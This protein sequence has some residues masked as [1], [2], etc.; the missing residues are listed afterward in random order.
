MHFRKAAA[1]LDSLKF[2]DFDCINDFLIRVRFEVV[3]TLFWLDHDVTTTKFARK[4]INEVLGLIPLDSALKLMQ[5]EPVQGL[6]GWFLAKI[7][8]AGFA[9]FVNKT[10]VVRDFLGEKNRTGL[11]P[12]WSPIDQSALIPNLQSVF[13]SVKIWSGSRS[14]F[15]RHRIWQSYIRPDNDSRWIWDCFHW[16]P[17][18]K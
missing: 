1:V 12:T 18:W 8:F 3:Q 6:R 15:G 11:D 4:W 13:W 7:R 9:I 16:I 10:G 17:R 2:L 5:N 14:H